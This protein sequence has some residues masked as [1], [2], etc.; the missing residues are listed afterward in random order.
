MMPVYI[1]GNLEPVSNPELYGP[2]RRLLINFHFF[3]TFL[4]LFTYA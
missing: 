4:L 2:K 3:H 1:R